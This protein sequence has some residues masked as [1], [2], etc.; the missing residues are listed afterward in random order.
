MNERPN[1]NLVKLDLDRL[2]GLSQPFVVS[3]KPGI[4]LIVGANEAGKSSVAR[5]VSRLLWEDQKVTKPFDVRGE[6]EDSRG[7]IQARRQ[8][9][10]PVDWIRDGITAPAPDLPGDHLAA[11]YRLGLLD[12]T[13]SGA[14]ELDDSLAAEIRQ[15]MAGGYDLAAAADLFPMPKNRRAA[16][17]IRWDKAR[18]DLRLIE[19]KHRE[20]SEQERGLT[21]LVAQQEQAQT[22][23]DRAREIVAA[24][25][26]I[27]L[28]ERQ[29]ALIDS[30][31]ALPA[32][33]NKV[34]EGDGELWQE[35][36][37][38][39][40]DKSEH[41]TDLQDEIK[42]RA[43]R[44]DK[45]NAGGDLT[46][47]SLLV[48]DIREV[49]KEK[50]VSELALAEATARHETAMKDLAPEL[51]AAEIPVESE[52]AFQRLAAAHR[53]M[54]ERQTNRDHWDHLLGL[55]LWREN[56]NK[57]NGMAGW[58]PLVAGC[59]ETTAAIS[60]LL[61]K[62]SGVTSPIAQGALV[63]LAADGVYR[64]FN[65]RRKQGPTKASQ[66][67][68]ELTHQLEKADQAIA[69]AES[70]RQD[71]LQKLGQSEH[72]ND[73]GLLQELDRV[74]RAR[75]NSEDLAAVSG[76]HE[77]VVAKWEAAV[78]VTEI[79]LQSAGAS[80]VTTGVSGIQA[81]F[82]KL[83]RQKAKAEGLIEAQ[84]NDE[85]AVAQAERELAHSVARQND[86]RERLAI[87]SS[88]EDYE[89]A[90]ADRT[91][92][93]SDFSTWSR[94]LDTVRLEIKTLEEKLNPEDADLDKEE[95]AA[96]LSESELQAA[97]YTE[98][99]SDII[100]VRER[101]KLARNG[102]ELAQ[103]RAEEAEAAADLSN[104]LDR[105]RDHALGRLIL[106]A[107]INEHESETLPPLLAAMNGFLNTFTRGLYELRVTPSGFVALDNNGQQRALSELSD[108]TRA[109][110]LLAARLGFIQQ[111]ERG[112]QA[113]L[114]LD[115]AF[116]SSDPERFDAIAG[117]MGRLS[118]T[119]GRQIFY[120]TSNPSDLVAWQRALTNLGLPAP[121]VVDLGVQKGL[122]ATAVVDALSPLPAAAIPEPGQATAKEYAA[123][124]GV[125][126]LEP[127]TNENAVP[128]FYLLPDD[129]GLLHRLLIGGTPTLGQWRK[130]GAILVDS[131]HVSAAEAELLAA[132]G[133][134]CSHVLKVWAVGRGAPVTRQILI[135]SNALSESMMPPAL[136]LLARTGGDAEA[137]MSGVNSGQIKRLNVAKKHALQD[138][139]ER[140]GHWDHRETWSTDQ[141]VTQVL[142]ALSVELKSGLITAEQVRELALRLHGFAC[143]VTAP[144][145]ESHPK[146]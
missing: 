101:V 115:E 133:K 110:L 55:A 35:I 73:L 11:C 108:G 43:E 51:L 121:H 130:M 7:V 120:L 45:L 77:H 129:L 111:S 123:A 85:A 135:A 38:Q 12:L 68:G 32:G 53:D 63:L 86:L 65:S 140:N 141:V 61:W 18:Q 81:A 10:D 44:L 1:L 96:L 20:L 139:L 28:T 132:R 19:T 136:D 40:G 66:L 25:R 23:S 50:D 98:I 93:L 126:P 144:A 6:F 83:S 37:S 127:W 39:I 13:R 42:R 54:I 105:Q 91:Q 26:R 97:S 59:I 122:A 84:T 95:L 117:A 48:Q 118:A 69:K 70:A 99:T 125:P 9:E 49:A 107:T 52:A 79:A 33:M 8:D 41:I 58:M 143:A 100:G 4:N 46:E 64:I 14:A 146:G 78:S 57:T 109:Q 34:R 67:N 131:G 137:F 119:T 142:G 47:V 138:H 90:L 76:R 5:A 62:G 114:F 75:A 74:A 3:A 16:E 145:G 103:A 24:E 113:P 128:C 80:A 116:T 22:A 36:A 106:D 31:A 92:A 88:A 87:E 17:R 29:D 89:T 112:V 124:I 102:D 15:Q 21:A 27:E 71:L 30:L 56:E 82:E 60:L 72:R 134:I 94:E 2:P 104:L